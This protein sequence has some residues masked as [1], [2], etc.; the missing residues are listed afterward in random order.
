[1]QLD[2]QYLNWVH[3]DS[4]YEIFGATFHLTSDLSESLSVGAFYNFTS[5]YGDRDDF[6]GFEASFQTKNIKLDAIMAKPVTKYDTNTKKMNT[7]RFL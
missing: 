5:Y 2:T 3:Y 1:M 4:S 6:N 7:K